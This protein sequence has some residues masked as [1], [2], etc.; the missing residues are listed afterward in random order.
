MTTP[1]HFDQPWK[2]ILEHYFEPFLAFFFSA[3][4]ALIDWTQPPEC[5]NTEFLQLVPE[6]SIGSPVRVPDGEV[7]GL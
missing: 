2:E 4:H 7:I 5:L 3:V 6:A 1:A